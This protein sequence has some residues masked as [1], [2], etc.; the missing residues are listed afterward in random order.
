MYAIVQDDDDASDSEI[1]RRPWHS[2]SD[3]ASLRAKQSN[4]DTLPSSASSS[5]STAFR[6]PP[7]VGLSRFVE[8]IDIEEEEDNIVALPSSL[9]PPLSRPPLSPA[10]P[11]QRQ[12]RQQQTTRPR[13]NTHFISIPWVHP[14]QPQPQR[15]RP[16]T[17]LSPFH[18]HIR[19]L[20]RPGASSSSQLSQPPR[21]RLTKKVHPQTTQSV[22]S[23][24]HNTIA[25][26]S[27]AQKTVPPRPRSIVGLLFAHAD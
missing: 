15:Q 16:D 4:A 9:P 13:A 3:I 26:E 2:A 23:S 20:F 10:P 27:N 14:A 24:V 11:Q 17:P 6:L 8:H 7:R 5:S 12:Q 19:F 1:P 25:T 22:T 18:T 21:R